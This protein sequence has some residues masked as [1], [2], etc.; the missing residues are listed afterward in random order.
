MP[1]PSP[2]PGWANGDVWRLSIA[3]RRT[4]MERRCYFRLRRVPTL[5]LVRA[6]HLDEGLLLPFVERLVT[7]DRHLEIVGLVARLQHPRTHVE[8]LGRDPQRA[9]DALE[10]VGARLAQAALD[11]AEVRVRDPG[12]LAQA[13]QREARALSL[14][15]DERA[16]VAQTLLDRLGDLGHR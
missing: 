14:V 2:A 13:A 6:V 16:E 4:D 1:P 11:L 7:P 5:A 15:A 9:C 10:D 8:G 12:P 3:T